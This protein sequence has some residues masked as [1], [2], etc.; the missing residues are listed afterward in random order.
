VGFAPVDDPQVAVAS[1]VV[2]ERLWR[3]KAPYV[4]REAL[5]AWFEGAPGRAHAS[6]EPGRRA[7]AR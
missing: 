6:L 1:V 3:V 4:A 2:N 5:R 7:V